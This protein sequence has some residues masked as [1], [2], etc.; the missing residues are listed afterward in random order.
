MMEDDDRIGT[1]TWRGGRRCDR[2][3]PR[4]ALPTGTAVSV[5]LRRPVRLQPSPDLRDEPRNV[6][7]ITGLVAQGSRYI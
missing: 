7:L 3:Y 4:C 2:R 1:S 5:V 6:S